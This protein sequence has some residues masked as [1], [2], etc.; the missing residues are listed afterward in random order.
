MPELP[1]VTPEVSEFRFAPTIAAR[2]VGAM[3]VV[4]ALLLAVLTVVVAV[5]G[6]P[7]VVLVLGAVLGVVAVLAVWYRLTR[8]ASVVRFGPA[9]Y[10]VRMLRGTGVSAAA[11]TDVQEVA[12]AT[13]GGLP[14][15]LLRLTDGGSTTI[16]VTL[17]DVDRE[18]FVRILRDHLQRGQGLRPLT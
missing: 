11:W 12:T 16:P 7:V 10:R 6:L 8:R 17:L 2:L 4:L 18:Q 13:P 15:V 9:G 14:V 1:E 5:A 3:L